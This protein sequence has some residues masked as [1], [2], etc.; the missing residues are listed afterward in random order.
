MDFSVS[1]TELQDVT[2][3][4]SKQIQDNGT[5]QY[6]TG[7]T[8]E[9]LLPIQAIAQDNLTDLHSD[10]EFGNLPDCADVRCKAKWVTEPLLPTNKTC[11]LKPIH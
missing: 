10:Q 4:Q 3:Q 5:T 11:R 1:S 8:K 6:K 7:T 2:A 9:I